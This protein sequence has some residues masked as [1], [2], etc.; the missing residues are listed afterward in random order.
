MALSGKVYNYI[1][2]FFLKQLENSIPIA[3]I[4]LAEPEI[5]IL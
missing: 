2:M 5:R 1:R 3:D 4:D